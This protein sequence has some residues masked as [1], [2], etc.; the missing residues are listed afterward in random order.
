MRNGVRFHNTTSRQ[1]VRGL[2]TRPD[3]EVSSRHPVNGNHSAVVWRVETLVLRVA[4]QL[5][6]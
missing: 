5:T 6:G 2:I 3:L 1:V 4:H